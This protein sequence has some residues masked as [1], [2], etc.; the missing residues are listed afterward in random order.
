MVQ[1]MTKLEERQTN[2]EK[3]DDKASELI[4]DHNHVVKLHV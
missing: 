3:L 2:L 4:D 1:N